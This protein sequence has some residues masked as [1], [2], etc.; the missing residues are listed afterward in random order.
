MYIKV[1]DPPLNRNIGKCNIPDIY[2]NILKDKGGLK[3]KSCVKES[4]PTIK[5]RKTVN[6]QYELVE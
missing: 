3:L 2:D 4:I 1:N 6:C 5:L